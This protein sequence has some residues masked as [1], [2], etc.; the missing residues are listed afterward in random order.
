MNDDITIIKRHQHTETDCKACRRFPASFKRSGGRLRHRIDDI[1][2]Q[3]AVC[4][5]ERTRTYIEVHATEDKDGRVL[6]GGERKYCIDCRVTL[7]WA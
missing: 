4:V 1:L 7:E 6:D 2:N 5:H 3:R